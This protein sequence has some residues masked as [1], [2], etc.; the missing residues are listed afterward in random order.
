LC[1]NTCL[2]PKSFGFL[3]EKRI[4]VLYDYRKTDESDFNFTQANLLVSGAYY[5]ITPVLG[6][7]IL[8]LGGDPYMR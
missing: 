3:R 5:K 6:K 2:K 1:D 8:A 4:T 7:G